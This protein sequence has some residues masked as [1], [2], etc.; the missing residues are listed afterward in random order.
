[1]RQMIPVQ[2]FY[3]FSQRWCYRPHVSLVF[4][5]R[6]ANY[7]QTTINNNSD[8][9]TGHHTFFLSIQ[10][11]NYDLWCSEDV[12][13]IMGFCFGFIFTRE[14][15]YHPEAHNTEEC[16]SWKVGGYYLL[17]LEKVVHLSFLCRNK[18]DIFLFSSF[19]ISFTFSIPSRAAKHHLV[20]FTCP[21]RPLVVT[22]DQCGYA[23]FPNS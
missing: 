8:E 15:R 19:H 12:H 13:Q 1:M 7:R 17:L 3:R 22:R 2:Q 23:I 18:L 4:F 20:S 9:D 21:S 14:R 16:S 11:V 5:I 6:L 10:C